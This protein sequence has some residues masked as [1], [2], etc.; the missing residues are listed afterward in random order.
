GYNEKVV[1]NNLTI[2]AE[3]K[4]FKEKTFNVPPSQDRLETT[5]Y[6]LHKIQD[7]FLKDEISVIDT[8]VKALKIII[9]IIV[10]IILLLAFIKIKK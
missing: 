5:T 9:P 2:R 10:M 7:E 4:I 8:L 1:S 3:T 6:D